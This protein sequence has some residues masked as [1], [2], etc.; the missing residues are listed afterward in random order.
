MP[1]IMNDNK[2]RYDY[3]GGQHSLLVLHRGL[4]QAAAIA[5]DVI[6]PLRRNIALTLVD[7][8]QQPGFLQDMAHD[9]LPIAAAYDVALVLQDGLA[10]PPGMAPAIITPGG[11]GIRAIL[12]LGLSGAEVGIITD[13]PMP[14]PTAPM[15]AVVR[16]GDAASYGAAIWQLHAAEAFFLAALSFTDADQAQFNQMTRRPTIL[17]RHALSAEICTLLGSGR[18]RPILPRGAAEVASDA[19]SV[20]LTPRERQVMGLLLRG[21][22]S[23]EI[24]TELEISPRTVDIHRTR[25][26]TKMNARNTPQMLYML[27]GDPR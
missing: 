22:S 19:A 24:A 13:A 15:R 9:A 5:Q 23:K 25:L 27:R 6:H 3:S 26:L 4:A 18:S 20:H 11:A 16:R 7:L 8:D 21:L 2:D 17:L 10:V 1:I 12:S 14:G